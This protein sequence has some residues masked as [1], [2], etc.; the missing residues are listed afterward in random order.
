M[1]RALWNAQARFYGALRANPISQGILERENQALMQLLHKI[2]KKHFEKVLD[3]GTG[4]GNA[5]SV[6]YASELVC[7]ECYA[8]DCAEKMLQRLHRK[9]P[10][11]KVQQAHAE[12]LPFAESTFD[13]VLCVGVTEYVQNLRAL[14]CELARTLQPK[15]YL[16]LTA[17]TR[18]WL[19]LLRYVQLHALFLREENEV[20]TLCQETGFAILAKERTLLQMQFLLQKK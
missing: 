14:L 18:I 13:L 16:A 7:R 6:L 10:N 2:P 17:S 5:L 19:N 9:F 4:E 20:L 11:V 8:V 3:I 15:G 12:N 1:S